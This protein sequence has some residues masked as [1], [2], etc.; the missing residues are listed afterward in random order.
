M[1]VVIIVLH[2]SHQVCVYVIQ[3]GKAMTVAMVRYRPSMCITK[4][5]L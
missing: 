4:M 5:K 3:D 1:T 2:V